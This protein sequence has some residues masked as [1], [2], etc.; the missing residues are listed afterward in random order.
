VLSIVPQPLREVIA[1][2]VYASDGSGQTLDIDGIAV[3]AVSGIVLLPPGLPA[4]GRARSGIELDVEVGYGDAGN[5]VPEPLR[6]AI[7]LLIS[8][9][10]ENR[11]TR[12]VPPNVTALL[13]PYRVIAL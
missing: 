7:R 3:D 4:P 2:R 8:H 1:A 10:Y 13:A 6:H 5:D 9:W 12:D 11:T